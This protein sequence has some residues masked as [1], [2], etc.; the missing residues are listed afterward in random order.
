MGVAGVLIRQ[1]FGGPAMYA[2]E[3]TMVNTLLFISTFGLAL[4]AATSPSF[5][6]PGMREDLGAFRNSNPYSY[7]SPYSCGGQC[8]DAADDFVEKFGGQKMHTPYPQAS[9]TYVEYQ[10]HRFD[11][12]LRGNLETYGRSTTGIGP[13]QRWF[14][15]EQHNEYL[16]R[17]PNVPGEPPPPGWTDPWR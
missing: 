11:P 3:E 16:R 14:S 13:N 8:V 15:V 7:Q 12:T 5:R 10:G 9:H 4:L 17:L 6:M 1:L 2:E